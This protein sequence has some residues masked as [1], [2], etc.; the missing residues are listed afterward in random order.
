MS[1]ALERVYIL[2]YDPM[3]PSEQTGFAIKESQLESLCIAFLASRYYKKAIEDIRYVREQA[4]RDFLRERQ[5]GPELAQDKLEEVVA[6]MRKNYYRY[7]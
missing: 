2:S 6:M 7:F 3:S 5:S 1:V 4:I